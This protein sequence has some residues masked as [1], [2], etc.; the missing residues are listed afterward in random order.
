MHTHGSPISPCQRC[1]GFRV[2]LSKQEQRRRD[3]EREKGKQLIDG[4]LNSIPQR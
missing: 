1:G 3:C 4:G 2:G